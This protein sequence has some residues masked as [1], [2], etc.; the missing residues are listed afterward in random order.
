MPPTKMEPERLVLASSSP[1]RSCL[2][3]EHGYAFVVHAADVE[4]EKGTSLTPAELVQWNAGLKTLPIADAHPDCV[5]VGADTIVALGPKIFGKPAS[6]EEAA[7]MLEQLNGREHAVYSGVCVAHKSA[8]KELRF[9]ERTVVRFFN[10]TPEQRLAY[11]GRIDPLD[12]AGAYAAQEDRSELIAGF[13]GSFSNVI[14]LPME[15]LASLLA[16]FGVHPSRK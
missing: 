14:G 9:V 5:V 2:L 8:G 11:L 16:A 7:L 10:R 13:E 15:S 6:I 3:L 12:K 1:R 4:E